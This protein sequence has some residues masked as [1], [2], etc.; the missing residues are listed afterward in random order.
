MLKIKRSI[1][2]T[3]FR[4]KGWCKGLAPYA[5]RT[6]TL[7]RPLR[8]L[9]IRRD[10]RCSGIDEYFSLNINGHKQ[11][12]RI[13][14]EL[15]ENP[16]ILYLHGGPGGSQIPSFRHYQL[17]WERDFTIVHWEQRGAGKSWSRDLDPRTVTLSQIVSDG[18]Q[19]ID[20]LSNR[21]G[22][23]DIVLLGHS[24]G[25]FLGIHLLQARPKAIGVYIGIGQITNQIQSEQ[26]M[27][28]FALNA[29]LEDENQAAT[30]QLKRLEGYPLSRCAPPDVA[31]VR[32][33]ARHYGFLGSGLSD[34]ARTYQRLMDTPEYS[35]M[36]IYRFLKGTLVSSETPGKTMLTDPDVQ[37]AA[38][39]LEFDVP[40]YLISGRRDHFTPADLADEYLNA[41]LAPVKKHV[42]FEE[43]GHYPNED[44]PEGFIETL[45][46]LID[47]YVTRPPAGSQSANE[48]MGT[49]L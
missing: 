21:F 10:T 33:W 7:Q 6:M 43:S 35:L 42:V 32:Q 9:K 20:Y 38:M 37:P 41:V 49:S 12:L 44:D 19:V 47:P 22:R 45:S 15:A 46:E 23:T 30:T 31:A 25:T 3:I 36:D 4:L 16:V 17:A 28:A 14:G 5:V 24:W 27:H 48:A 13:R 26:R 34:V 40:M 18:L 1:R 8:N 39:S 2:S 29:A 11:W